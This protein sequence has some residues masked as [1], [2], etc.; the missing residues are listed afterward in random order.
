MDKLAEYQKI[1][2]DIKR[3]H[4]SL[5]DGCIQAVPG[6]G[7]IESPVVFIGEGPGR[8]EDELGQPFV[9]AAG[10]LLAEGL[11][12]IGLTRED[13]YITNVV[14]CRPPDNRDPL[15]EEVEE[16][17]PFLERELKLIQPKL[18]VL[19]GRHALHWFLPGLQI[20]Q[21]RGT[22]KRQGDRVFF[23]VYHP[24]A[25]LY[26]PKLRT[27]FISDIQKIPLILDKIE[28]L[29]DKSSALDPVTQSTIFNEQL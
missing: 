21:V 6:E 17:K 2:D 10:K 15:P 28:K 20:S 25:A 14:K 19:L 9:G 8:K 27:V 24:A 18:I 4:C 22:A 11:A 1:V 13:V 26:D 7:N 12:Q 5:R 3:H 16:H 29:P 23:P